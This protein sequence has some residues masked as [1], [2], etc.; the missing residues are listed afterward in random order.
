MSI[1]TS[2]GRNVTMNRH[3]L[4]QAKLR[5]VEGLFVSDF[6]E[7]KTHGTGGHINFDDIVDFTSQQALSNWTGD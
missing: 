7:F 2:I 4:R 6:E 1:N 3:E 5:R